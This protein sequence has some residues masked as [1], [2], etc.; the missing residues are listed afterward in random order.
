MIRKYRALNFTGSSFRDSAAQ[1][2]RYAPTA[3]DAGDATTEC[4]IPIYQNP[5][6]GPS[7]KRCRVTLYGVASNA[8]TA[9]VRPFFWRHVPST[10]LYLPLSLGEFTFTFASG[11]PGVDGTII[12]STMLLAN[13]VTIVSGNTDQGLP[14]WWCCLTSEQPPLPGIA[15]ID[16]PVLGDYLQLMFKAISSTDVNALVEFY[17]PVRMT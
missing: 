2:R 12:P 10:T 4:S 7:G 9:G 17:T 3:A 15:F 11:F 14:A 5:P 8:N 6:T 13:N 1:H 16:M